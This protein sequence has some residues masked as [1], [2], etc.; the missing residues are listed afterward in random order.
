VTVRRVE[1]AELQGYDAA[2]DDDSSCAT[3]DLETRPHGTLV[4]RFTLHACCT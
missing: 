1:T 4:Y 2:S 3:A